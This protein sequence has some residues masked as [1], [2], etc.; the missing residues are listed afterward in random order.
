MMRCRGGFRTEA[1]VWCGVMCWY[2]SY[3]MCWYV[4]YVM[5]WYVRYVVWCWHNSVVLVM[6][7]LYPNIVCVLWNFLFVTVCVCVHCL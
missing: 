2:V 3:V 7:I 1:V 4:R 6:V 5:C